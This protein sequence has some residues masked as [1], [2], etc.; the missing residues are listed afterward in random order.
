MLIRLVYIFHFVSV[1]KFD[2]YLWGSIFH[3]YY[4]F[5]ARCI[6]LINIY[7]LIL[8]DYIFEVAEFEFGICFKMI[9]VVFSI[10]QKLKY[11]SSS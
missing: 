10:I 7:I 4:F 9:S 11:L 8:I 1:K 5:N 2:S 3:F 6:K